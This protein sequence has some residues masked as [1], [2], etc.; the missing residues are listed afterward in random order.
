MYVSPSQSTAPAVTNAL[1]ALADQCVQ[2]G[3]CLPACPT[4]GLERLETESP[5]G[6]F[7]LARAW[8]LGMAA[9][10]AAGDRHLDQCLGCGRCEAVCPAGVQYGD[11]LLAAR[12][13]QRARRRPGLRQRFAEWMVVRPRAMAMLLRLYRVVF[14]VLPQTLRCLP[15]PPSASTTIAA[16]LIATQTVGLFIGCIAGPYEDGLRQAVIKLC[17]ALDVAVMLPAGQACCGGVHA[18]AGDLATSARLARR[19]L[20]GFA[21][22]GTVLTL[23]SGCHDSVAKS[24]SPATQAIDAIDFIAQRAHRL[25]FRSANERIALHLPCTQSNRVRSD[26][27]TRAVL[28]RIP[29]IEIVELMAGHG[30]CGAAGSQMLTDPQRAATFR[31]PLLDQF[32]ASGATRL[33]SANIGCR[34]HFANALQAPAQHPLEYLAGWIE[35]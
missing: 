25:H 28:A 30:C 22:M 1:I 23:A 24:L 27:A 9:P 18:H 4:Y 3:L 29:G 34:L 10:T 11:L 12:A 17:A 19:N 33:L 20:A 7:A 35:S 16:P 6:R 5:R 32:Q 14:P 21:S 8:Q 26:G 31:Q 15:R 13:E 2:C